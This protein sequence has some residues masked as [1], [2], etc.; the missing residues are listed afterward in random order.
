M[1]LLEKA[2]RGPV[3]T[4]VNKELNLLRRNAVAGQ[5]LLK[6]LAR[7]YHQHS[8]QDWQDRPSLQL[9]EHPAPKI[10]CSERLM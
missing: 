1:S 4:A 2:F 5:E 8:M 6:H 3:T 10:V 7:L 9:Q